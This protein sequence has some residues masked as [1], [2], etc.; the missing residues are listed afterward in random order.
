MRSVTSENEDESDQPVFTG[1]TRR[2]AGRV[3]SDSE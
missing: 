2:M 3:V 1:R